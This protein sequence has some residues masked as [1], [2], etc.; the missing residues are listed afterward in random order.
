MVGSSRLANSNIP[1]RRKF[2]VV[3]L[4]TSAICWL[5][6]RFVTTSHMMCIGLESATSG[7]LFADFITENE[8]IINVRS[9][10]PRPIETCQ[11]MTCQ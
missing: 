11:W 8:A 2:A 10:A 5:R 6:H 7:M 3:G 1:A 4:S 9:D